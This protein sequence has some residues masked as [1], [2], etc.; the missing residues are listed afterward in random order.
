MTDVFLHITHPKLE[1]HNLE[2]IIILFIFV[3]EFYE[4]TTRHK[5]GKRLRKRLQKLLDVDEHSQER[6][7]KEPVVR[8]RKYCTYCPS[9]I[10]RM[11]KMI[12]FKCYKPVCGEHKQD[13]CYVC[14]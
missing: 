10:R 6:Q 5:S 11:S 9:T 4:N 2:V 7:I 1:H 13:V 12:C 3:T 8:K 14:I